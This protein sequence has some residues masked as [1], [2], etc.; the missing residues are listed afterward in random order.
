MQFANHK[1]NNKIIINKMNLNEMEK[2]SLNILI[3]VANIAQA[4]GLLTLDDAYMVSKA[5]ANL[6]D[7][8]VTNIP[9]GPI[10]R[11]ILND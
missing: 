6:S 5:I 2:E 8:E 1:N 4:N 3:N 11:E 9:T 10:K 7:D